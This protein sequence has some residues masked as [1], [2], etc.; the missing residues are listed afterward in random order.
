MLV[1][2][3]SDTHGL[4]RSEVLSALS[5]SDLIIHAGDIGKADV[6]E[7]LRA[8]APVFAV[9]GNVDTGFWADELPHTQIVPVAAHR[10]FVLHDISQLATDPAEAGMAAVVFGHS[11][12]PSIETRNG[13]LYLNPGSAGPQRFKLPICIARIGISATRFEPSLVVLDIR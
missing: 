6:L 7:K 8:V 13:V 3:L 11:H 2:V 10:F 1:G 5:G 9:R 12:K 4:I